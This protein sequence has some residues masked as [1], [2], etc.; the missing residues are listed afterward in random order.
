MYVDTHLKSE[1]GD[2]KGS[3]FKYANYLL[4]ENTH[5]FN[6]ERN[7]IDLK[8]GVDIIDSNSK[9]GLK[10]KEAKWFAPLY[11]LSEKEARHIVKKL[12]NKDVLNFSDLSEKEKKI[13]NESIIHFA[14]NCQNSMASNFN[15]SH[16]G[17]S[18]GSD[19]HYIGVVE[20][21]RKFIGTDEEVIKGY[22]K[23]GDIKPGFNTHIHI[24]QS[25]KAN[26]EKKSLVSPNANAKKMNTKF[27]Q[28]GFDRNLFY[29]NIEKGFDEIFQYKRGLN[30]TLEYKKAS[31]K[32]PIIDNVKAVSEKDFYVNELIESASV[33]G[34]AF[35]EAKRSNVNRKKDFFTKKQLDYWEKNVP[36]V[37]YFNILEERGLV[38]IKRENDKDIV[39]TDK[40]N[41]KEIYLSKTSN[42]WNTFSNRKGGG[43]INAIQ[44]F[45][46]KEWKDAVFELKKY[47]EVRKKEK[48]LKHS[49]FK[50][51]KDLRNKRRENNTILSVNKVSSKKMIS[52]LAVSKNINENI[53][54]SFFH[55]IK[56]KNSEGK[57]FQS[58]GLRNI[59]GGYTTHNGKN[60]NLIGKQNLIFNKGKDN[61]GLKIFG[62]IDDFLN[63]VSENKTAPKEDFIILNDLDYLINAESIIN[64]NDYNKIE[65]VSD[66][67]YI[68]K[69]FKSVSNLH[70]K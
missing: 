47:S 39:F 11:S 6:A 32:Q 60:Q 10:K 70:T 15:K 2:N 48:A 42:K 31:S 64:K 45:E 67:N 33:F 3:S 30:E 1:S 58:L 7:D 52:K 37:N 44:S 68:K 24:I 8:E 55:Q 20:H 54:A 66:N 63:Y 62:K 22:V 59:A 26:N 36:L 46:N 13:F 17:I 21:T 14:R 56:I 19:L 23:S 40:Q 34:K 57:E 50:I 53:I 51:R 69:K 28:V 41:G 38:Q 65:V 4:K 18:K 5:F 27:G 16:L 9:G 49:R 61:R 35:E 25:R 43:I 29:K 12:F